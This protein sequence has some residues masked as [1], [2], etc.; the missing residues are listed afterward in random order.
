[1]SQIV[2]VNECIAALFNIKQI[3][4][5]VEHYIQLINEYENFNHKIKLTDEIKL[6]NFNLVFDII[7]EYGS[8]V[9]DYEYRHN[10]DEL[11]GTLESIAY[12]YF[13][14]NT[15]NSCNE[16]ITELEEQLPK[17]KDNYNKIMKYIQTNDLNSEEFNFRKYIT[18]RK[19][20]ELFDHSNPKLDKYLNIFS[21]LDEFKD[22]SIYRQQLNVAVL[23]YLCKLVTDDKL[24]NWIDCYKHLTENISQMDFNSYIMPWE[25]KF[26]LTIDNNIY[27][28]KMTIVDIID[29]NYT[30]LEQISMTVNYCQ[31]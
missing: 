26:T 14:D 5:N 2:E 23:D 22:I 29:K 12:D 31:Q 15:I 7:N 17:L 13:P 24:K 25:H 10:L 3:I 8:S 27:D 11:I 1:M 9:D 6:K 20:S 30:T 19:I 28:S 16:C 4:L 21:L 18:D